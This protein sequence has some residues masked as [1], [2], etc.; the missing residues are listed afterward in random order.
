MLASTLSRIHR[1]IANQP[2]CFKLILLIRNQCQSVIRHF[3]NQWYDHHSNGEFST[4]KALAP[5]C[6]TFIDVGAHNGEWSK[7]FMQF[8]PENCRGILVEPSSRAFQKLTE[9][10]PVR[11]GLRLVNGAAG[12]RDGTTTFYES[13]TGGQ[14]SSIVAGV[15]VSETVERTVPMYTVGQLLKNETWEEVAYLKID[16][17]GFDLEVMKGVASILDRVKFRYIQFEYNSMWE[18]QNS[19]LQTVVDLFG[20]SFELYLLRSNGLWKIRTEQW[21]DYYSYSN[22]LLVNKG[23]TLPQTIPLH[24]VKFAF[25]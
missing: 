18:H 9:N 24:D 21:L 7:I 14:D 2:W 25:W 12:N 16:V 3:F 13:K 8:A 5:E 1:W 6:S 23:V 15:S 17:E 19:R 20:K 10:I 4:L 22:Y 11:E